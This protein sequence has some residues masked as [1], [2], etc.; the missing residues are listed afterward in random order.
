MLKKLWKYELK[1]TSRAFGGL[2]LGIVAAAL[3]LGVTLRISMPGEAMFHVETSEVSSVGQGLAVILMLVYMAL[4]VAVLVLTAVTI[5]ERFQK[6]LLGGE[7]YLMHTLPVG[8]K[9]LILGKLMVSELWSIASVL[10]I[11]LSAFLMAAIVL[12]GTPAFPAELNLAALLAAARQ[13]F[14]MPLPLMLLGALIGGVCAAANGILLTYAACM[15]GHQVK[16]HAVPA[17][18]L[19]FIVLFNAQNIL[20]ALLGFDSVRLVEVNTTSNSIGGSFTAALN[21][22]PTA[23][24]FWLDVAITAVPALV[25]ATLY[26]FLAD[27]LMEK[28]LNLE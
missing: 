10:V 19:A 1:A 14:G 7:G 18:I 22:L 12:I 9:S 20:T 15:I 21:S 16:K 6:N 17:G 26:F 25:F 5:V 2:Y 4:L 13:E 11:V 8:A 23:G 24:Q 3:A 27:W 28:H